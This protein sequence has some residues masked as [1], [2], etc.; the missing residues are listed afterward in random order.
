MHHHVFMFGMARS[1]YVAASLLL[2]VLCAPNAGL[3]AAETAENVPPAPTSQPVEAEEASREQIIATAD[4]LQ[5]RG[6]NTEALALLEDFVKNHPRDQV[7]KA[8]LLDLRV[9]LKENEIRA[10][11]QEQSDNQDLI[12]SDPEYQT[13]AARANEDIRK[14]L[15]VVEYFLGQNRLNEAAQGCN[16]ILRDYPHDPAAT[17]LKFRILNTISMRERKELLKDREYRRSESVNDVIEDSIFPRD[18][19]RSQRQVFVFQEDIDDLER[20]RVR[21]RLQEKISLNQDQAKVWDVMRTLFAV[22]GINYVVLDS[23]VGE[24]TVSLH[25]VDDTVE[26]ALNVIGKLAK[27]RFSYTD[28]TV[29]VS[30]DADDGLVTEIIRLR[31]GLTNVEAEVKGSSFSTEGGGGN[32]GGGGGGGINGGNGNLPPQVQQALRNQQQAQGKNGAN[33]ANGGKNAGNGANGGQQGGSKTDL[34]KFLDSLPDIIVGWQDTHKWHLDRK[35][36]TLYLR[37]NPWVIS[38]VKRLLHA[39]DYNN[40]QVLIESRFVEV[41]EDALRQIGVDWGA[42]QG[43]NPANPSWAGGNGAP[44]TPAKAITGAGTGGILSGLLQTDSFTLNAT[45]KA[46]EEENKADSLAEPK[47]LTLNNATGLIEIVSNYTYIETYNVQTYSDSETVSNGNITTNSRAVA[48]PQWQTEDVGY[49]LKIT[50]SIARNSDV[51]TLKLLPTVRQLTDKNIIPKGFEYVDQGVLIQKDVSKP[52]FSK[53]TLETVLHVQNGRTV[54]LGGLSDEQ[55]SEK[56]LGTPFVSKIPVLGWLFKTENRNMKRRNLIIL[57]TANLVEPSGSKVGDDITHLR[58][59]ARILM[60]EGAVQ[61][62]EPDKPVMI[63]P[64]QPAGPVAQPN[65][66]MNKGRRP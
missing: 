8:H 26:S 2:T 46:L 25:L 49:Q 5:A 38:E 54:A 58:D 45:L 63:E 22:A 1:T 29:F 32:S 31:S 30:S 40:V 24:E 61:G 51:I 4:D 56:T 36:N 12:L 3:H 11:L 6:K 10:T 20:T 23:A 41:T 44:I 59:T 55:S 9:K 7:A 48:T 13:L 34:E 35:S 53:R 57:V 15:A 66:L 65:P 52:I 64:S 42:Y 17:R 37:A 14:R 28:G 16:A 60:P 33:G 21:G 18:K 50:P 19:P 62:M 27:V 39:L 47:I 43:S